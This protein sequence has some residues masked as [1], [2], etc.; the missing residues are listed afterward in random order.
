MKA[1]VV[2][3]GLFSIVLLTAMFAPISLVTA[4]NDPSCTISH[5]SSWENGKMKLVVSISWNGGVVGDFVEYTR[6]PGNVKSGHPMGSVE[7]SHTYEPDWVDNGTY[8]ITGVMNIFHE[9]VT[10]T[11]VNVQP[12][13]E[14]TT[15]IGGGGGDQQVAEPQ[16]GP[17]GAAN[18]CWF[19]P[20]E[21]LPEGFTL[22][23]G[24]WKFEDGRL[25]ISNVWNASAVMVFVN[26][27][28]IG[29]VTMNGQ[30]CSFV[31]TETIQ[32][33]F[34]T[35]NQPNSQGSSAILGNA[36]N[37]ETLANLGLVQMYIAPTPMGGVGDTTSAV[38]PQYQGNSV[39][40]CLVIGGQPRSFEFRSKLAVPIG[41]A[42]YSG[43]AE[44]NINMLHFLQSRPIPVM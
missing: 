26:N 39:V 6:Q 31:Q 35:T 13:V 44:Q 29:V 36:E 9:P 20:G 27:V 23:Q 12:I 4:Q 15:G 17:G 19:A 43:T 2:I 11:F 24:E 8:Q 14:P 10:C 33:V 32:S 25:Q 30:N 21:I 3:V 41:I 1:K 38:C 5:Q 22:N 42:D 37:P 18:Y 34:P 28:E 7:G 16:Y 40:D